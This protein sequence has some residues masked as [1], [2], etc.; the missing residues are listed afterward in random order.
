MMGFWLRKNLGFE[1]GR[2]DSVMEVPGLGSTS[3]NTNCSNL[4]L[5]KGE[6][7]EIRI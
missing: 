4:I 5:K 3:S 7:K 2:A 1:M 6:N